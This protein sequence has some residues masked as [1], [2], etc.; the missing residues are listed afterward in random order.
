MERDWC[1][2][3]KKIYENPKDI[4]KDFTVRDLLTAKMHIASCDTCY[5]TV[6]KT[7]EENKP[8]DGIRFNLN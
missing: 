7:V 1:A 5:N 4:V 6:Y 3:F 8:D 2:F